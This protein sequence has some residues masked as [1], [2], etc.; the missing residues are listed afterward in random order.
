MNRQYGGLD[1]RALPALRL[2]GLP[3]NGQLIRQAADNGA[4]AGGFKR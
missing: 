4:G 1:Q 3:A 2:R